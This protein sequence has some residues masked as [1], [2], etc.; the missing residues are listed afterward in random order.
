MK[1]NS[2]PHYD[3]EPHTIRQTDAAAHIA[4]TRLLVNSTAHHLAHNKMKLQHTTF[5][6]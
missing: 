2:P 5:A 4:L 1:F 6:F 3:T